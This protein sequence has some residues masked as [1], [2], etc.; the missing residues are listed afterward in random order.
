MGRVDW[1][2]GSLGMAGARRTGALLHASRTILRAS[3]AIRP[4]FCQNLVGGG[5]SDARRPTC[6]WPRSSAVRPALERDSTFT[7]RWPPFETLRLHLGRVWPRGGRS[8]YFY[9][10]RSLSGRC[11]D[12]SNGGHRWHLY[13]RRFIYHDS[14]WTAIAP[15]GVLLSG[16][17]VSAVLRPPFVC[18]H[19]TTGLPSLASARTAVGDSGRSLQQ[20]LRSP[21]PLPS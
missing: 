1:A 6:N 18:R 2:G 9:L 4:F 3:G 12:N 5:T 13:L 20:R 21:R 8:V 10:V 17:A 15:T 16:H 11:G 19:P 14:V 7:R